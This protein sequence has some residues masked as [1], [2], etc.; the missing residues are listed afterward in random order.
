MNKL[1]NL[2][3]FFLILIFFIILP[4]GL[5][6]Q[7]VLADDDFSSFG[8]WQASSGAWEISLDNKLRQQDASENM[9]MITRPLEQQGLLMYQFDITIDGGLEDSYGGVGIHIAVTDPTNVRSWGNGRSYL[10][11]LTYDRD[12]YGEESFFG[13][14]YA[15]SDLLTMNMLHQG[16]R[17]PIQFEGFA[18]GNPSSLVGKKMTV[19]V[20]INTETGE[21]AFY[22]PFQPHF[23]Y[24]FSFGGPIA[25]GT[26]FSFR[27]NS[28]IVSID[29]F[30]VVKLPS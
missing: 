7:T 14:L 28:L 21:G 20:E 6:A 11:W 2:S 10:L 4:S 18:K 17:Y 16:T 8:A 25:S 29:N 26:H 22:D 27:T 5:W 30:H 19:S 12:A 23:V 3:V 24:R 15:S 13:Q 9:A 1:K